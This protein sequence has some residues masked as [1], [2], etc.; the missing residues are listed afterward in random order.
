MLD[1][2]LRDHWFGVTVLCHLASHFIRCLILFQPRKTHPNI[3]KN[4]D[5]DVILILIAQLHGLAKILESE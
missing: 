5:W 1:L 4:V 3:T 2:R